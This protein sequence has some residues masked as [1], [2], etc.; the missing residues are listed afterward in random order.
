ME[1]FHKYEDEN[2]G[3]ADPGGTTKPILAY[4][5]SRG[6]SCSIIG[7]YVVRDRGLPSLYRR[8]VYADLCEGQLRSLAPHLK[9]AS[10]DHKLGVAVE[11][12]SSFG[13]DDAHRV[14]VASIS[15]PVF[16]L[17]QK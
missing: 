15:G 17:V 9:R 11:S 8:Y 13:E 7:G 6:G 16:R 10:G 3:T 5:H 2:S 14:Y 4:P 1:G 12:P